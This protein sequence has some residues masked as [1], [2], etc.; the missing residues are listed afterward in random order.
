[1][2]RSSLIAR[3]S[4]A[5]QLPLRSFSTSCPARE[6]LG[7]ADKA[8]FNSH[9]VEGQKLT[10]VDFHAEWCPPCKLLGPI[11]HK[12]MAAE[13]AGPNEVDFATVDTDAETEL[14]AKYKITSLPTVVAFKHGK[15]LSRFVGMV[16]EEAVKT[17]LANA[18][19]H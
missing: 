5:A 18:K 17:F 14:A 19:D 6:V 10:I 11:L 3:T 16:N 15:E 12:V 7:A 9:I 1:M 8:L 13:A 4:R 2:L